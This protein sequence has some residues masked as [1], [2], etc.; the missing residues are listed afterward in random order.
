MLRYIIP[1]YGVPIVICQFDNFRCS[2]LQKFRQND[3]CVVK[4][5]TQMWPNEWCPF[6]RIECGHRDYHNADVDTSYFGHWFCHQIVLKNK[7]V[8][9]SMT[10]PRTNMNHHTQFCRLTFEINMENLESSWCELL[11]Y[12]WPLRL[13]WRQPP[14]PTVTTTLAPRRLPVS[15]V[16]REYFR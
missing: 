11:R 8:I 2:Q 10:P 7:T 12:R 15:V 5:C 9:D 4:L 3:I 1:C 14:V 16:M 6:N 13:A